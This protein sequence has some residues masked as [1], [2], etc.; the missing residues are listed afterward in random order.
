MT[1]VKGVVEIMN[2]SLFSRS[3]GAQPIS[4]RTTLRRP[5]V[6][7]LEFQGGRRPAVR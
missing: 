6:L 4:S 1:F 3:L 7:E 5:R 2:R